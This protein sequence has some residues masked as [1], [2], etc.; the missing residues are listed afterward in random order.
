M[1]RSIPIIA[2]AIVITGCPLG[3][4][5]NPLTAAQILASYNL[6]TTGDANTN[7]DIEGSAVVGGNANLATV[8]GNNAP[9]HPTLGVYGT[10]QGNLNVNNGGAVHYGVKSASINLNGGSTAVQGGFTNT[11]LDFTSPL[12]ALSA[13]L[14]GLAANS[15]AINNG[16]FVAHPDSNGVA[17]FNLTAAALQTAMTNHSFAFTQNGATA[18]IVNVDGNYTEGSSTNWN[19]PPVQDVIFNFFDA[20]SVAV[21]N[22]QSSILAPGAAVSILNGN[23]QGF[24]YAN[25]FVGG[26]ELHNFDFTGVLPSAVPEPGTLAIFGLA[27]GCLLT[28]RRRGV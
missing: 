4:Y 14:A 28:V 12:N 16:T 7:S 9:A 27:L 17:V 24:V 18:I 23:V 26:G 20:T 21:G 15:T 25:S 6:V 3:A 19:P 22:W 8:F 13:S 10:I 2:A 1:N 11:L 5:A